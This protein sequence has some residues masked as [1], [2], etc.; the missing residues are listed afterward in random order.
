M[1]Y[2]DLREYLAVLEKKGLLCHIKTE[3]DKDWELPGP[4]GLLPGMDL[5]SPALV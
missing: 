2:R 3:V 4:Y 1:P 5:F